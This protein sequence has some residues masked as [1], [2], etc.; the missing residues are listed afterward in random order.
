MT[1]IRAAL[2]PVLY[3]ALIGVGACGPDP[4]TLERVDYTGNQQAAS[5]LLGDPKVYSRETL[6][7]DRRDEVEF[8]EQLLEETVI[9]VA[10]LKETAPD[11][12]EKFKPQI[13][14]EIRSIEALTS[15]LGVTFDPSQGAAA[16]RQARIADL[17]AELAEKN[18][19]IEIA[20]REKLLEG[21]RASEPPKA[22]VSPD[23]GTEAE[24]PSDP[25]KTA[26][27]TGKRI[28]S[29]QERL[30]AQGKLLR[31]LQNEA[32]PKV[33]ETAASPNPRDLF[34][35]IQAYRSELR[36]ALNAARLDDRHDDVGN[37][38]LRLQFDA[39]VL[40]G[41]QPNRQWGA[42]RLTVLPPELD[43]YKLSQLYFSWLS[44]A[45][46]R[47]NVRSRTPHR[48]NKGGE[49]PLYT[50]D[51]DANYYSLLISTGLFDVLPVF[52]NPERRIGDKRN[53][54]CIKERLDNENCSALYLPIP[55]GSRAAIE[56]YLI[57]H[58]ANLNEQDC[59]ALDVALQGAAH[60][61]KANELKSDEGA[62]SF[63]LDFILLLQKD[64][65][66]EVACQN[67]PQNTTG[68]CEPGDYRDDCFN[69]DYVHE[70][71]NIC[72]TDVIWR[73]SA[74]LFG[75]FVTGKLSGATYQ[76]KVSVYEVGPAELVERRSA[77]ASAAQSFETAIALAAALPSSGVS[78][79]A[80]LGYMRSVSGKVDA[81]ERL[82]LIIGYTDEAEK[83][84]WK[85][86]DQN[87]AAPEDRFN[88]ARFGWLFGPRMEVDENR[89][90]VTLIQRPA[91]YDVVAEVSVPS[92]W[93][94]MDLRVET[95]WIGNWDDG[96]GVFRDC[97]SGWVASRGCKPTERTIRVPLPRNIEAFNGLTE[98]VL[99]TR[100]RILANQP[101]MER[102]Y[103]STL[104]ACAKEVR[105]VIEGSNLWRN[106]QVYL[107]GL[108]L[109]EP[110]VLPDMRG[111]SGTIDIS[112]Y[113]ELSASSERSRT[114]QTLLELTV[115]TRDG[116]VSRHI[117]I[118][119]ARSGAESCLSKS[120][121]A[122][123]SSDFEG[124]KR[125]EPTP[126][127]AV[128]PPSNVSVGPTSL[129]ACQTDTRLVISGKDLP[130]KNADASIVLGGLVGKIEEANAKPSG[131]TVTF[132]G[133]LNQFGK[134][135]KA[136]L[137]FRS[138]GE[139]KSQE[140]AIEPC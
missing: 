119:G 63:I 16:Q 107:G 123:A 85:S 80:G 99:G 65:Q 27:D 75:C 78:I 25:P 76:P 52:Y 40:P 125:V 74:Y 92:W 133:P 106:P 21:V 46:S 34:H 57:G 90:V 20:R 4:Y 69:V 88:E 102:I 56:G 103:P 29:L 8:L 89:Q 28:E 10:K 86:D 67:K 116:V 35:D 54:L 117:Q 24:P 38:L 49:K 30:D 68:L 48:A 19:E 39:T 122:E 45:A 66:S 11:F 129:P 31:E 42:A 12:R 64:Q 137:L 128:T 134:A 23:T 130:V 84:A 6:I 131:I 71:R 132:P 43:R 32:A 58:I 50:V 110:R 59:T 93:P 120:A 41:R 118:D 109:G 100:G 1:K 83:I 112:R 98:F 15:A 44:Y 17:Q 55:K 87:T 77:V 60:G 115:A 139:T 26:A 2:G 111:I 135:G 121:G 73:R 9:E 79:D 138:G 61:I 95:A 140:I 114:D 37:A 14:S 82:P 7:N 91:R 70:R 113:F 101:T 18:L 97:G 72:E 51:V 5:I 36:S 13:L 47:L 81:L 126:K 33:R 96:Q 3:M 108:Q 22:P 104:S 127:T 62:K 124:K 136:E 53:D 94:F 105:F